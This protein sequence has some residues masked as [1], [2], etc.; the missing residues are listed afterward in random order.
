V[1]DYIS[2]DA[3]VKAIYASTVDTNPDHFARDEYEKWQLH[4]GINTGLTQAVLDVK[5]VP[6]ADVVEVFRCAE[7]KYDEHCMLQEFV[8]DERIEPYDKTVFFCSD[9]KRKDGGQESA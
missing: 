8:R 9:G 2:R 6:A 5:S 1:G 3:A 4:N 7:C